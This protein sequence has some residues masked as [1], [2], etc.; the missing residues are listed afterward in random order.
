[1]QRLMYQQTPWIPMTYPDDLEAFNTA[2]WSGWTQQYGGKGPAWQIEGDNASYLNLRPRVAASTVGSSS[3]TLLV[4]AVVVAAG[5]AAIV[6]IV[7]RR[8]GRRI[9]DE[10]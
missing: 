4:V 2:K 8:R 6:F 5:V 3:T 9:E 10:A 7:V 1:M